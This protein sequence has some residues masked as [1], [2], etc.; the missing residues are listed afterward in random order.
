MSMSSTAIVIKLVAERMELE[1]EHGK[2]VV[3]ILLFQDLAVVPLLV[4]IPALAADPDDL[5]PAL[6]FALLKAVALLG[7]C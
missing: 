3:G 1:S 7:C 5:L 4:L 2:R 6:G